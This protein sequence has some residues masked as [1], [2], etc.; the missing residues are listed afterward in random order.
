MKRFYTYDPNLETVS[1]RRR[2]ARRSAKAKLRRA[3]RAAYWSPPLEV[4]PW[5][6]R[7]WPGGFG[8]RRAQ[9]SWN[10]NRMLYYRSRR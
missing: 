7:R 8:Y 1:Y 9:A 5:R 3:I 2:R 6:R 4:S 10:L